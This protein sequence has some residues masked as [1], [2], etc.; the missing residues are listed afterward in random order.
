[1]FRRVARTFMVAGLAGCFAPNA[2]PGAPC[3]PVGSVERCPSG[4]QCVMS[5]GVE[6]CVGDVDAGIDDGP[7]GDAPDSGGA[8]DRDGDGFIDDL[9]NCRD[10]ANPDQADEDDDG[11]GDV[12]DPC[13]PFDTNADAD[14]D[15]VGD[16]C[17]PHPQTAGD[18]LVSFVGFAGDLPPSW[19][20]EG[21][22]SIV[23]GEGVAVAEEGKSVRLT[24][25]S[26]AS[27][28][29]EIRAATTLVSITAT[30][31]DLGANG[32]VDRLEPGTDKAIVCQ[33]SSLAGGGQQQLRIF[34][35][36]S[37]TLID[38]AAH[39]FLAE[40]QTELRLRRTGTDYACRATNPGL[41]LAGTAA[42]APAAPRIGLR[43]RSVVARYQWVMVV[44]SP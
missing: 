19:T 27:P 4:Q 28:S 5:G 30:G 10:D 15:G 35:T 32:L 7:D 25:A 43:A 37:S 8:G 29:I 2:Q 42:F 18:Q 38:T 13:P 31:L 3:A 20:A 33:L 6:I 41:E 16:A 36:A 14:G 9:D 22:F 23:N 40:M 44:R 12:C 1:M 21:V 34:D 24:I 17:D 39:A 26:P 11:V